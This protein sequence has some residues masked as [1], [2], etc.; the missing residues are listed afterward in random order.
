MAIILLL[1]RPKAPTQD[2]TYNK[3]IQQLKIRSE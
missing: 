3:I 2:I 1:K